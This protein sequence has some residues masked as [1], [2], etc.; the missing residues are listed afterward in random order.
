MMGCCSHRNMKSNQLQK[1][2]LRERGKF[3]IIYVSAY[4]CMHMPVYIIGVCEYVGLGN[5]RDHGASD[6]K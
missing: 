1:G 3:C 5:L 2:N 4:M 6:M